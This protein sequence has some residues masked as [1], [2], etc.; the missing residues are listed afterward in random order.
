MNGGIETFPL[1]SPSE[2]RE[3]IRRLQPE[4]G[5][6]S[7]FPSFAE[8]IGYP[9]LLQRV[10]EK[11]P[12][13]YVSPGYAL[14]GLGFG[15]GLEVL[16]ADH[17]LEAVELGQPGIF[18]GGLYRKRERQ[19]FVYDEGA[20]AYRQEIIVESLPTPEELGMKKVDNLT[21]SIW[22]ETEFKT[23]NVWE[24]PIKNG[25]TTRLLLLELD[26]IIYPDEASDDSRIWNDMVL[27]FG[28][29][30]IIKQL[31]DQH[32]IDHPAFSHFQE[33]QMIFGALGLLDDLVCANGDSP[34]SYDVALRII[35]ENTLL[36]S[37]TLE[38]FA[39]GRFSK[40]Q[41]E[42]YILPNIHSE[43]VKHRL[44]SFMI[45]R[46][47]VF[48]PLEFGLYIAG[49][50]NAVSED[51]AARATDIFQKQYGSIYYG[52][53]MEITGIT[54]GVHE[55]RWN[56]PMISLLEKRNVIDS[57]GLPKIETLHENINGISTDELYD[58]KQKAIIDFR[59]FLEDGSRTDQFGRR[60]H[61]PE[62]AIIVGDAR[63]VID[64]KRRWMIFQD[65]QRLQSILEE[66][67]R[68]Y[69]FMS[70]KAHKHAYEAQKQLS[71]V[72][73]T[74]A[75]NSL[76]RERIFYLPDWEPIFAQK[77]IAACLVWL[78]TPI[79]GKEACG[80]SGMKAA[81]GGA[82]NVSTPDGWLA[83]L[84]KIAY[85]PILGPTDSP[86]EYNNYYIQSGL[87]IE[88]AGNADKWALRVKESWENG[89]LEIASGARMLATYAL[90]AFPPSPTKILNTVLYQ[91]CGPSK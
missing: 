10:D 77:K 14:P 57:F 86:E 31:Q 15:G 50:Y 20:K 90:F 81:I 21:V 82:L 23:I 67:K 5:G 59:T 28:S 11:R 39:E 48:A 60:I 79:V 38:P 76:F 12:I 84:P 62:D 29:S 83:L 45:S 68:A 44:R 61:I 4:I 16:S 33:S 63:R 85:Y 49:R 6:T 70:G 91:Y 19:I 40:E 41:Y 2:L 32:I 54:N 56:A 78:N 58:V 71:Y 26:G 37:H 7:K 87:A 25:S 69:Y 73:N 64:Y 34:D 75:G 43:E 3:E 9:E 35:R 47:G 46:G 72:L 53:R 89:V 1:S 36:T 13:L 17:F 65:P 55:K 52:G 42:K 30:Q 24:Y 8:R 74:I 80:T 88:H 51:N 22:N 27:G 66:N 18:I